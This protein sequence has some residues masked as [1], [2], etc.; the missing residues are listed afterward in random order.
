MPGARGW[1]VGSGG[2]WYYCSKDKTKNV[3][4]YTSGA[5]LLAS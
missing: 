5:G 1:A 3:C 4:A 2:F